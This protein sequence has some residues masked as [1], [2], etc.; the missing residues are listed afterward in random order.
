MKIIKK[1]KLRLAT[2]PYCESVLQYDIN[3]DIKSKDIEVFNINFIKEYINIL[4]V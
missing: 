1:G 4:L 2:C 3:K